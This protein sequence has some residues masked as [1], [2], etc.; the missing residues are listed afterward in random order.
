MCCICEQEGVEEVTGNS[1]LGMLV[2]AVADVA[3]MEESLR[4]SGDQSAAGRDAQ[5][6]GLMTIGDRG[7]GEQRGKYGRSKVGEEKLFVSPKALRTLQVSLR[8]PPS[9]SH[10]HLVCTHSASRPRAA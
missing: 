5:L 3:A 9:P 10:A 7:Q 8:P 2:A 4:P 1:V 6:A